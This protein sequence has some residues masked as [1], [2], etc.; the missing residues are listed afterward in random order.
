[1]IK[2]T[3]PGRNTAFPGLKLIMPSLSLGMQAAGITVPGV[4][5]SRIMYDHGNYSLKDEWV[6]K[7]SKLTFAYRQ[8]KHT[9]QSTTQ[10]SIFLLP[11]CFWCYQV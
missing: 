2:K 11:R 1:M 8:I 7:P 10:E 4:T 9:G 3:E 5:Q 6:N